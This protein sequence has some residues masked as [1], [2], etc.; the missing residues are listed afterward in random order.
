MINLEVNVLKR[1]P[2][3]NFHPA[4]QQLIDVIVT[5]KLQMLRYGEQYAKI[6]ELL[7]FIHLDV[8]IQSVFAFNG[9]ESVNGTRNAEPCCERR[10]KPV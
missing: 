7:S 9:I 10:H 5:N 6:L 2:F 8:P 1:P 3:V 4:A